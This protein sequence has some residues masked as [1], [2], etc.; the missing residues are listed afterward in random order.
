MMPPFEYASPSSVDEALKLLG[1]GAAP[2]AGG[3]DLLSLMKERVVEPKRLVDLKRIE[4][5][6][7]IRRDA[8]SFA[9][10]AA[11]TLRAL[12]EHEEVRRAFPSLVTAIEGIRS[13]QILGTATVGGDLCQRPRCWYFRS[14]FGLLARRDGVSLPETGDNRYHAILGNAGPALFVHPSGL[15]PALA[16]LGATVV[17]VGTKGERPIPIAEFFRTPSREGEREIALGEREIVARV[18]VPVT[19]GTRNATYEVRAHASL[20]WPLAA[21]A[22]MTREVSGRVA[23]ARIVL[24]HVAPIPWRAVE[25]ERALAGKPLDATTAREAG[26]L[27]VKGAR[28][29]SRNAY[30]VRLAEVA[31]T[32]ALLAARGR[33]G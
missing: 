33:E 24:G 16:A 6:R 4:A 21:A 3:T 13:P 2:L 17:V 5:L 1:A 8:G 27:A 30:K 28:P 25:A 9:I 14:G 15:A 32:R 18:D 22:V 19:D 20:D 12:A 26:R 23:E 7:G 10:G 29:L 11:T 31:V